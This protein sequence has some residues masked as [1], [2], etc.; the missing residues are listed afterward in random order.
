MAQSVR[1]KVL[2][3]IIVLFV[4][5][6]DSTVL[7][8][9]LASE[10][11]K[12]QDGAYT[13]EE[14]DYSASEEIE[15]ARKKL[16]E[17]PQM[18]TVITDINTLDKKIALCFEGTADE[19]AVKQILEYLEAHGMQA[20]FFIS[21]IDAGEDQGLI[22][23]II[24]AGHDV[25]SYTLY[26]T[27]HM[28]EMN[29]DELITDF[30]R[31]QV[32]YGDKISRKPELMK[33][34]ATVYTD[35]LMQ[36]SDASGY[37]SIVFPTQY[38]N[39]T[40]FRT[41]EMA[42]NYVAGLGRGRVISVKLSGYLDEVEY[43]EE[44]K[45]E[46]K[47]PAK[48]KKP[49]LELHELE[50]EEELTE[51]ERLLQVV[52]WLLT[53]LD[54]AE[55]ETVKLK[56]FPAQDMGDLVLKYEEI[57][58]QY[59]E[60]MAEPVT[61]VHT[62]DRECAFTFRGISDAEELTNI[63]SVLEE[64][65]SKATFF[66]TGTEIETYPE[67]IQ[68]I[69][70]AGHELGN[71]GYSGKGMNEMDFAQICEEIYKNDLMLERLSVKTNLF[72][73]PY[74]IST[75]DVQRAAAAC[76]KELILYNASPARTDYAE[77]EYD[78]AQS[79]REYF[80]NARRVLCRGDIVYFNMAVYDD[81]HSLS[82]LVKEVYDAKVAP[83]SYGSREGGIFKVT[84]VSTLM[85]NTWTYSA[86]TDA[87]YNMIQ[88][89]GNAKKPLGE[90]LATHYIGTPWQ[91]L[92]GFTEEE[93][94]LIDQSGRINTGGTNT[95]FLTFDDWGDEATIGRL[96]YV[97]KKHNVK[98]SFF[99]K[100]EYV[101]DGSTE[102]LLRAIAEGGHDVASHTERH[103]PIDVTE[104]GVAALQNDLV[105]S[106]RKLASIVG[107]T[108]ALK[109]YFRPPTLAVNKAGVNAVYDCGYEWIVC[110][111]VS[112]GDYNAKSADDVLD[113]L[114]NGAKKNDGGRIAIQDGSVVVM[115]INTNSVYTAQ[116]LDRYLSWQEELP[117]GDPEKFHF[118]KLSDYLK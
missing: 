20:A 96:L 21:A 18:P 104:E 10:Q 83:A 110:G 71:G 30:C 105:T 35:E 100:T 87:T 72:M 113:L 1:K 36:A 103:I 99:I 68:Q 102:N 12:V 9:W 49:G 44:K 85:D 115:H 86:A 39:Y 73:P 23:E 107:N 65:G 3:F 117:E 76:E 4:F 109:S 6:A 52:D 22:E 97:L 106:N 37:E 5:A 108:G 29:Q 79:V 28:E 114:K 54:E 24:K 82:E 67:Q 112:T 80:S 95:V 15:A 94:A 31:A 51:T 98:A 84:T 74:G 53:S 19:L 90:A 101:I 27:P 88:K 41:E 63:L 2:I 81:A 89:S 57:E 48:D 77:A 60:Q 75:E 50:E 64:S 91:T 59:L 69:L 61:A 78:A 93:L 45:E 70:D 58:E 14:K 66:V 116:G 62:T 26:G 47:D 56:D 7:R 118:A 32:V 92:S 34:N 13:L 42:K 40:S 38:L 33:C 46:E 25:E 8:M 17:D 16:E 43:E 111:E 55:Y 11:E